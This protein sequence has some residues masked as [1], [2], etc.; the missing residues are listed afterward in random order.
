M[1]HTHGFTSILILLITAHFIAD[2]P[3]QG[4]FLAIQKNP[5]L[6][7]D[8]RFAPWYQAMTAH[9]FIHAGFVF[10]ITGNVWFFFVELIAHFITDVGKCSKAMSYN[11]DQIIHVL[12]KVAFAYM[13]VYVA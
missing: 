10:L 9:C 5:W 1:I 3:L 4:E 7:E 6:P 2:Y 11:V 12:W 8:K 13:V